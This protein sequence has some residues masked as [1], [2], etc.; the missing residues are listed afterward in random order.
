MHKTEKTQ[1][2]EGMVE[3]EEG[4]HTGNSESCEAQP[5]WDTILT[6]AT[7]FLVVAF[8][9]FLGGMVA[10]F[11]LFVWL[12]VNLLMREQ[13][14]IPCFTSRFVLKELTSGRMPI[15]TRRSRESTFQNS[16]Y[17]VVE[18]WYQDYFCPWYFFSSTHFDLVSL[19]AR[20]VWRHCGLVFVHDRYSYAGNCNGFPSNIG[21]FLSTGNK[22]L[23]LLQHHLIPCDSGPLHLFRFSH[24]WR[25]NWADEVSDQDF[26]WPSFSI[27]DNWASR[28][29]VNFH[30]IQFQNG[31]ELLRTAVERTSQMHSGLRVNQPVCKRAPTT[32]FASRIRFCRIANRH[33]KIWC[34][35]L[36][37]S[38]CTAVERTSQKDSGLWSSL[39]STHFYSSVL[40]AQ[41]MERF[42][43]SVLQA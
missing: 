23:F 6:I 12:F 43:V 14:P 38:F 41:R 31:L 25:Q 26:F 33:K 36:S 9:S 7:A 16:I 11:R 32:G 8:S 24:V 22:Y 37:R 13:T 5:I 15:L 40:V 19:M 34:K 18:E 29:S 3:R 4:R 42:L 27:S 30:V 28:S 39:S 2:L 21:L 20:K 10:L 35:Y 17:T 1:H